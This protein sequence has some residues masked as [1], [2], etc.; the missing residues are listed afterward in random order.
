M[1]KNKL[2]RSWGQNIARGW[3]SMLLDRLRDYV[4]LG[5]SPYTAFPAYS[6]HCGPDSGENIDQLKHF[7]GLARGSNRRR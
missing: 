7:H 4:I 2:N 5:T 1:C 3:A 6:D